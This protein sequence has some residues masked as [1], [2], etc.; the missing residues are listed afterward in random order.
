MRPKKFHYDIFSFFLES[1][2][3]FCRIYNIRKILMRTIADFLN[4]IFQIYCTNVLVKN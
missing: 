1:S 2:F 4:Y 3:F